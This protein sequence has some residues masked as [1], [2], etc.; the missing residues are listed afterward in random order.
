MRMRSLLDLHAVR[1]RED[2]VFEAWEV[3]LLRFRHP[4][5][6]GPAPAGRHARRK[7]EDHGPSVPALSGERA[8]K[9]TVANTRPGVRTP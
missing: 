8:F 1:D 3:P 4:G 2:L 6:L 5:S 7:V 9:R